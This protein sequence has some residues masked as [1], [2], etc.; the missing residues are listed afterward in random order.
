M[1]NEI[2]FQQGD[3]VR[4]VYGRETAVVEQ[5]GPNSSMVTCEDGSWYHPTKVWKIADADAE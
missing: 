2:R 4:T 3:R 5:S 1:T